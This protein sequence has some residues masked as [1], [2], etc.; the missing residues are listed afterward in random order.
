MRLRQLELKDAPL[1]LEWMHD[2][3]V[4]ENMQADFASKT[5]TDCRAF[6]ESSRDTEKNLHLAIVNDA[7]EYQGTVSLKN[8]NDGTAEFAITIRASAMGKGISRYAMEELL[9]KGFEELKLKTIFWCVDPANKRAVR[10]Y[11]KN[12]YERTDADHLPDNDSYSE[13]QKQS[14]IWYKVSD[15]GR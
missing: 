11:D 12:A 13:D 9:K 7:D 3:S 8:I 5:L 15:N 4:V 14:Y 10:F 1:M 6:I 2:P